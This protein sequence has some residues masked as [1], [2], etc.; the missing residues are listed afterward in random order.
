MTFFFLLSPFYDP[1]IIAIGIP[2]RYRLNEI[3]IGNLLPYSCI[4]YKRF[5]FVLFHR[6]IFLYK[7]KKERKKE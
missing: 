5:I 2:A 6:R 1:E 3:L 7:K 4:I